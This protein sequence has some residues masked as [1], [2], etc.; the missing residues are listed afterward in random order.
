[1]TAAE[2]L[3]KDRELEEQGLSYDDVYPDEDNGKF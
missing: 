3:A 1:M 2:R